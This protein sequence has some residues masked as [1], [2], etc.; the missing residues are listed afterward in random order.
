MTVQGLRCCTKFFDFVETFV[1][2]LVIARRLCRSL[3]NIES[4]DLLDVV[5]ML[6]CDDAGC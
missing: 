4:H 2:G 3:R 5:E 6:G 1:G